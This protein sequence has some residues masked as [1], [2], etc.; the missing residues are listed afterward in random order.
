MGYLYFCIFEKKN[1]FFVDKE[2]GSNWNITGKCIV[3]ELKGKSL[4]PERHSN[5]FA[6]AWLVFHPDSEIYSNK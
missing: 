4:L 2:T 3:G 5:H 6:F 1:D